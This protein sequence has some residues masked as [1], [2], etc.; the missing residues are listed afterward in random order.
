MRLGARITNAWFQRPIFILSSRICFKLQSS[1][2]S[3][4]VS[5]CL[6]KEFDEFLPWLRRK[7]GIEISSVLSIG[8]SVYGR[9]LF[10]SKFIQAGDCV[11]KVPFNVQITP[12]NVPPE[13]DSFLG[14]EVGNVARLAIVILVE[15]KM[16]QDSE[17]APYINSL[18]QF[19][20]LHSTIFWSGEELE[21]IRLS[22]VYQETIYQQTQIEKEF[23]AIKPAINHF[24]QIFEDITFKDFMHV[25]ALEHQ[26]TN[27][28]A[29]SSLMAYQKL[30]IE[31][32]TCWISCMGKLKG[33]I[34][35]FLNHDGVSEAVVLSD[36]DK[37]I[38]EVI[39]DR[40]YA[41][42]EQVQIR[43][44]IPYHDPLRIMKYE[45]LH[46]HC[47]PTTTDINGFDSGGN[48]FTIKLVLIS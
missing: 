6:N 20:E 22:S 15:Q 33:P 30:L 23:S 27:D 44:N 32:S 18:P 16:V 1:T 48:S 24:P 26:T 41:P 10:A 45:I 47:M 40:D 5:P 43:V 9:S 37:Q 35:D 34:I 12:V 2:Y 39:A 3:S 19:G 36:E 7:A 4:K 25:H 11:L 28:L 46:K 13:I 42:G 38:S 31:E 14:D 8:N 17:W 21:M 29:F